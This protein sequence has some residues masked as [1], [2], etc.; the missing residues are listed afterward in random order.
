MSTT[1]EL[2]ST[3]ERL[4]G[5]FEAAIAGLADEQSIRNVQAGFIGKQ[6]RV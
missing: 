2:L 3:L 4:R 5:D 6:R 1:A